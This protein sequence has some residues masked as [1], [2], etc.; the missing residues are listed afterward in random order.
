MLGKGAI[1]MFKMFTSTKKQ[2]VLRGYK[3]YFLSTHKRKKRTRS[4]EGSNVNSKTDLSKCRKF[5]AD[6][7]DFG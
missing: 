3:K 2:K 6:L 4:R 5:S 7:S 1:Y